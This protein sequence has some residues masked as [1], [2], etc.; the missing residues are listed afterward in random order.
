MTF[1]LTTMGPRRASSWLPATSSSSSEFS[2]LSAADFGVY[3]RWSPYVT[4][5]FVFRRSTWSVPP[6]LRRT[7]ARRGREVLPD[8]TQQHR[9]LLAGGEGRIE[10]RRGVAPG[11]SRDGRS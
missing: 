7:T 9:A 11:Q 5:R 1:P 4:H 2:F 3:L 8:F 10:P 6:A